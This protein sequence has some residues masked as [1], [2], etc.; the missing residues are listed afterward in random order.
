MHRTTFQIIFYHCLFV[1]IDIQN[2]SIG[3]NNND[4]VVEL[5][6]CSSVKTFRTKRLY[7]FNY[8][9]TEE[10]TNFRKKKKLLK[11]IVEHYS[12]HFDIIAC[13]EFSDIQSMR[14][15]ADGDYVVN[16]FNHS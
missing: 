2:L 10:I 15:L 4:C 16:L 11:K 12:R 14:I 8:D 7:V 5:I 6:N 13:A 9:N 3:L 1:V